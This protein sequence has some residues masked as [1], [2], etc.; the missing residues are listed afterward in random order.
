MRYQKF[1]SESELASW[2]LE[3]CVFLSDRTYSWIVDTFWP[4]SQIGH[5]DHDSQALQ[6]FDDII[7]CEISEIHMNKLKLEFCDLLSDPT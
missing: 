5:T 3:F 2:H 7:R 4:R 1:I 6:M